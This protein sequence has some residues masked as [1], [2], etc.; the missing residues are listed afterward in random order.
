MEFKES[1]DEKR[2]G[3]QVLVSL[4]AFA[5][6]LQNL[7]GGYIVLGVA[8]IKG[9]AVRPVAGLDPEALD[10]AQRWIRGNCKRIAPVYMP[11]FSPAEVDGKVVLVLWAPASDSRPH[12]AP[13]ARD[14]SKMEYYVRIG[15]ESVQAQR[16]TLTALI[17]QTARV[18]FDDRRALDA[19]LEDIRETKVREF[20]H[21]VRSSLVDR[22]DAASVYRAMQITRRVNGSEAPRNVAL[23]F[24]SDNPE[25]WMRGARIEVVQFADDAGGNTLEEKVFKGA[26]HEQVRNCLAY[27]QTLSTSHLAKV[28]DHAETRGVVSYPSLAIRESVV[29]AVYHRSYEDSTEPVK[30]Y[31]YPDRMEVISYPGPVRGIDKE[32]ITG[33]HPL[34]P[35]PARNRRIGELLKELHLAEGR[36][37][38]LPKIYRSMEENGSPE[39]H[40]QFDADRTYFRVTLPAHAEF[41]AMS[42]MRD[43]AYLRAT[44]DEAG[45]IRRL[46]EAFRSRPES[47][48]LATELI[49]RYAE[50]RNLSAAREVYD[51]F[52]QESPGLARVATAMA[53]AYLDAHQEEDARVVLDK[54]P[55][56]LSTQEA[57][58]AAILER[59]AKRPQQAHK[60]FQQAGD[61]VT[62]D[63]RAAHEF[64]QTKMDLTRPFVKD[65]FKRNPRSNAETHARLR[66]LT[67]AE[68]LLERVV[69]MDSSP[70]RLGWAWFD[71]ARV[72]RWLKKPKNEEVAAL[73]QASDCCPDETRI[74]QDLDRALSEF[75]KRP[76]GKRRQ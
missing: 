9:V 72:R 41:L 69:Q 68:S 39:P 35:V 76:W 48:L 47:S 22:P 16:E 66:L 5:N 37:T 40:F 25:T 12:Q 36:G 4:C 6:D 67:E 60:L 54:M 33:E 34:P 55:N 8:E 3:P 46:K 70:T 21:D 58:N 20:L 13:S 7:N 64:A 49:K 57:F 1:W 32:D 23:L 61:A 29:N 38:G 18:P 10:S 17:Q 62:Q 52:A 63:A 65:H 43:S 51:A 28:V 75:D 50:Q 19:R 24:F 45:A 2:T 14:P 26:L 44:G 53:D 11:V 73:R 42:A 30:V 27:L 59:R 31:F 71:L 15:S 74:K 56:L